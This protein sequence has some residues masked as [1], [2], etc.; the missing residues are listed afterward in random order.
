[1]RSNFFLRVD[2]VF[3]F[4][5][6][7]LLPPVVFFLSSRDTPQYTQTATH[8]AAPPLSYTYTTLTLATSIG[9]QVA[10]DGSTRAGLLTAL[11]HAFADTRHTKADESR[12]SLSEYQLFVR[13]HS[14]RLRREEPEYKKCP[15]SLVLAEVA[16][17]WREHQQEAREARAEDECS[18]DGQEARD[19]NPGD[20][21]GD[22]DG[23][24]DVG[25]A[26]G[27]DGGGDAAQVESSLEL[28]DE[29]ESASGGEGRRAPAWCAQKVRDVLQFLLAHRLYGSEETF[30]CY[31]ADNVMIEDALS[32]LFGIKI[33]LDAAT[34][35]G[36]PRDEKHW[37][38][39]IFQVL[40]QGVHA[41]EW[42]R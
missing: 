6:A 5:S 15:Q 25:D 1:M 31:G 41:G 12:R 23:D 19:R 16:R 21:A 27:G 8:L 39:V 14:A 4:I 37:T 26:D 28:G 34:I 29:L 22:G 20:A 32:L 13:E 3:L 18:E 36:A 40:C 35:R 42:G 2:E 38:T 11:A 33:T 24:S 7:T 10:T 30:K 17:M 9:T